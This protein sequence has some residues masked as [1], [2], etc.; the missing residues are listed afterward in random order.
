MYLALVTVVDLVLLFLAT[1]TMITTVTTIATPNSA[2]NRKVSPTPKPT[3]ATRGHTMVR[4]K[5]KVY[6]AKPAASTIVG[7]VTLPSPPPGDVA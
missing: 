4:T 3:A 5:T 6:A 2:K 1:T 7:C